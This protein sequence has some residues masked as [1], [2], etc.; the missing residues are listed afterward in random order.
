MSTEA[1]A[2]PD[3]LERLGA[4]ARH[5][6][7]RYAQDEDRPLGSYAGID[8]VYAGVVMGGIALARS[9]GRGLPER[10][11]VGDLTLLAVA[12]HKLSRTLTKDPITSALRAPFTRYAGQGGPSEVHEEVRGTGVRHAVG[13]LVTCPFCMGQ[14]VAT[15]GLFGLVFA[16]RSTRFV[17]SAFA[18]VAG[19]DFLQLAYA[20]AQQRT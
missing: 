7:H 18:V 14:W 8:L 16:P 2:E 11:A 9:T 10:V 12:T 5:Q 13:E 3:P 20:A 19:S 15:A 6:H 4:W 1:G 17:A